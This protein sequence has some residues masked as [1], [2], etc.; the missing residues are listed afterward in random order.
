MPV[1]ERAGD[2]MLKNYNEIITEFVKD[3]KDLIIN[4]KSFKK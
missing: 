4:L 2:L 3:C 1:N